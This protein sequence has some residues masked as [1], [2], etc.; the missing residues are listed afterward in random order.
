MKHPEMSFEL[1]PE[2]EVYIKQLSG[3]AFD[4]L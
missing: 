2:D 3:I 1:P 4:D